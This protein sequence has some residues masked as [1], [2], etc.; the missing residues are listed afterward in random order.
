MRLSKMSR[1][2]KRSPTL[3]CSATSAIVSRAAALLTPLISSLPKGK[4]VLSYAATNGTVAF[5]KRETLSPAASSTPIRRRHRA[6]RCSGCRSTSRRDRQLR[7]TAQRGR[8][9]IAASPTSLPWRHYVEVSNG[10]RL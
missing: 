2:A 10:A 5:R 6:R 8:A 3:S 9:H 1:R 7:L 4:R